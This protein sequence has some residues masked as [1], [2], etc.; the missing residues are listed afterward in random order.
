MDYRIGD[1]NNRIL[2]H[3]RSTA[4]HATHLLFENSCNALKIKAVHNLMCIVLCA[5]QQTLDLDLKC[6]VYCRLHLR[7]DMSTCV[8]SNL[9]SY[10]SLKINYWYKG[11]SYGLNT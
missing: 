5:H 11:L 10:Q 4:H 6:K 9:S 1:E 3:V 2:F 8:D 7:T